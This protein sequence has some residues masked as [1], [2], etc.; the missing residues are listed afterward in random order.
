DGGSYGAVADPLTLTGLSDGVHTLHVKASDSL[1]NADATPETF[2][3]TVDTTAP[4]TTIVDGPDAATNQTTAA[5]DFGPAE[6]GIA[7]QANMDGGGWSAVSDPATFTGVADGT[8]TL[9]VRATDAAGNEDTTPAEYVWTVDTSVPSV[10]VVTAIADDTG[11]TGDGVTTDR[12]LTVSGTG[13]PGT[14]VHLLRG[15]TEIGTATVSGG[16]TWSI[17]D[18]TTLGFGKHAYTA[19]AT[20][21][22]GNESGLSGPFAVFVIDTKASPGA[23][24]DVIAMGA[25]GNS[26]DGKDG[27][28]AL[29]GEAGNDTVKGGNGADWLSGGGDQDALWGGNGNDTAMGGNGKDTIYGE[30]G[31]DSLTGDAGDDRIEGGMGSDRADGGAGADTV[32]G[33]DGTDTLVA[34]AGADRLLGEASGDWVVL[35]HDDAKDTVYGSVAHLAG[36]TITGFETG[37]GGDV[38][39]ITGLAATAGKLLD[40][41]AITG[42]V[43]SLGKVGGGTILFDDLAGTLHTDTA[44]GS[45][46]SLLLYIV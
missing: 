13:D 15:A 3:W 34:G 28:D 35:G 12:S 4:E 5:F 17:A 26:L 25:G 40:S 31:D 23:G 42:G 33:G 36:D 43:L 6:A 37:K 8:H 45:D 44:L 41:L 1:G 32:S 30:A 38:I 16:G 2:V 24:G 14:T 20:G 18:A 11:E 19:Y 22:T 46:G 7:F 29:F 27:N 21:G 39:A 9:Q 10:P